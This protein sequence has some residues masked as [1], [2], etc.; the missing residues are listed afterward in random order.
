MQIKKYLK[1]IEVLGVLDGIK[2]ILKTSY[3]TSSVVRYASKKLKA[4]VLLRRNS[5]D[6]HTFIQ[7]LIYK[8]YQLRNVSF[9]PK[10]IIDAGANIGLS[11]LYFAKEYPTANV[12]AVEASKENY[13]MLQKNTKNV[14]A[15]QAMHRAIWSDES[16]LAVKNSGSGFWGFQVEE[17]PNTG[18]TVQAVTIAALME[19]FNVQEIDILKMDI[20]GAEREV[21]SKGYEKWLP[22][23]KV[24]VIELHDFVHQDCSKTVLSA[25]CK[26]SFTLSVK[27]SENLVFSRYDVGRIS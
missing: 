15:I 8:Q 20:E 24:L 14:P 27:G 21:F 2:F 26:Y 13:D 23:T 12:L 17:K 6:I 16:S 4:P 18:E 7:N 5:S 1:I 19:E 22:R 25:I 10:F 3:G 11:A 9:T